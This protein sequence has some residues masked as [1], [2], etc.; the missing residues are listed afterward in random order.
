MKTNK[1]ALITG[2]SRGLG[3][4][5]A[6]K[7]AEKGTHVV[8]TYNANKTE[9]DKVLAEVEAKGVQAAALQLD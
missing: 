1:V 8:I 9:A 5:M 4:S 2:G 7:L 3:R 6:N